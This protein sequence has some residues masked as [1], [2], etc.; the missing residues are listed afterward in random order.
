MN[1]I[2]E[3]ELYDFG[4]NTMTL[5]KTEFNI[6]I[7][8][9]GTIMNDSAQSKIISFEIFDLKTKKTYNKIYT[10]STWEKVGI[11]IAKDF[12][13]TNKI[14][15]EVPYEIQKFKEEKVFVGTEKK[16]V[17]DSKALD[18]TTGLIAGLLGVTLVILKSTIN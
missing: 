15:E 8:C 6:N 7:V 16:K 4:E 9:S 18:K 3:S 13:G 17:F 10:E 2:N 11:D 1:K 5:L 14:V 12:F